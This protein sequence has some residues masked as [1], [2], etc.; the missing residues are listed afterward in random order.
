MEEA[1]T[2]EA[3]LPYKFT[4]V[5]YKTVKDVVQLFEVGELPRLTAAHNWDIASRNEKGWTSKDNENF[6]NF[7]KVY[8]YIQK[9][10]PM[11]AAAI[12]KKKEWRD[13]VK[14]EFGQRPDYFQ[15][16]KEMMSVTPLF[17]TLLHTEAI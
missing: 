17:N 6:N 9:H 3:S 8:C 13:G 5:E 7:V 16:A 1:V 4:G 11:Y 14:G 10:S 2:I 15:K 12:V